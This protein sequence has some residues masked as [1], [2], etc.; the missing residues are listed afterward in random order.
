V[1]PLHK[2]FHLW[3][4]LLL[5]NSSFPLCIGVAILRQLRDQLLKFGFNECILLFSDM[6]GVL[7]GAVNGGSRLLS[8]S[9]CAQLRSLNC[10]NCH[11][12]CLTFY[13]VLL[14]RHIV[15][16]TVKYY[17]YGI[18]HCLNFLMLACFLSYTL[19]LQKVKLPT[20]VCAFAYMNVV[21]H[22][23]FS[24]LSFTASVCYFH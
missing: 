4:M 9:V 16:A 15:V 14:C 24:F 21:S 8:V 7:F 13:D 10:I 11:V 6:P 22:A 17:F 20:F 19:I 2:I 1:F 3:D 23:R 5:G 12:Y 18:F